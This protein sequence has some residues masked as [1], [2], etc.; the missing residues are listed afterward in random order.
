MCFQDQVNSNHS[1]KR[2]S[3]SREAAGVGK[4]DTGKST[5]KTGVLLNPFSLYSLLSAVLAHFLRWL[6]LVYFF[7]VDKGKTAKEEARDLL[8]KEEAS[9]RERVLEIQKNLSLILMA[10]GEMAI[11][12]PVF[13][14]SQLPS[15]VCVPQPT[16]CHF[17]YLFAIILVA[18]FHFANFRKRNLSYFTFSYLLY[19]LENFERSVMSVQLRCNGTPINHQKLCLYFCNLLCHLLSNIH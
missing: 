9:I 5:K 2:E 19:A 6:F 4:K 7:H 10:L 8:L 17:L 14:H 13:A 12:N 1:T 11:A 15:L 3:A 18:F 16:S